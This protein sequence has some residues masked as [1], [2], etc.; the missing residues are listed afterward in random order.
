MYLNY[1][2]NNP[3]YI[4][5]SNLSS[6]WYI[7]KNIKLQ[8]D[9]QENNII[10][11]KEEETKINNTIELLPPIEEKE[12]Y[13]VGIVIPIFNQ[14]NYTIKC[15]N[16]ID[17]YYENKYNVIVILV[18]NGSDQTNKDAVNNCIN[19][20][21]NIK[22]ELLEYPKPIGYVK[23]TNAGIIKALELECDY[24]CLQN[25]DTEVSKNWMSLLINPITDDV[26]G[27][28]PTTNSKLA[29]QRI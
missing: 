1:K 19:E 10:Y 23:A 8:E 22:T 18:D 25:N 9:L 17:K 26:V 29:I 13:K 16:S 2:F 14:S 7:N 24:I 20:L 15:L 6:C 21:K 11:I 3:N 28:G 5:N 4:K 27:S 12:I